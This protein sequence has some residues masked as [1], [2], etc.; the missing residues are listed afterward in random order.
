VTAPGHPVCALKAHGMQSP[1]MASAAKPSSQPRTESCVVA[2]TALR[3]VDR[4]VVGRNLVNGKIAPKSILIEVADPIPQRGRRNPRMR[5]GECP[6]ML[7]GFVPLACNRRIPWEQ[8]RAVRF[9]LGLYGPTNRHGEGDLMTWR[10]SDWLIVLGGRESRPHGEAASGRGDV[11]RKHGL[12]STGGFGL[13]C[14][15]KNRQPW[16]QN[17]N[18]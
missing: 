14:N 9:K 13:L 5:H 4:E 15:E 6:G 7:P 1:E 18:E 12:H 17:S 10:K 16:K 11:R 8:G 2:T 3:S